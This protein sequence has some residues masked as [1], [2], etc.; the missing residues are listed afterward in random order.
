MV[1][2]MNLIA[3][4]GC[5]TAHYTFLMSHPSTLKVLMVILTKEYTIGDSGEGPNLISWNDLVLLMKE[6]CI[7]LTNVCMDQEASSKVVDKYQVLA[8]FQTMLE[9][10]FLSDKLDV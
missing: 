10:Y 4:S 8:I 5:T 6:A 7:T 9:A 1:K 3:K 2:E